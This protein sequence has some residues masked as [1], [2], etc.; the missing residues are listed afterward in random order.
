[1]GVYRTGHSVKLPRLT[2]LALMALVAVVAANLTV[3]RAIFASH[4]DLLPGC[5]LSGMVLEVALCRF[6]RG[7][8][9]ARVF[10]A[11]FVAAGALAAASLLV[12]NSRY[13]T[14][15]YLY[16][17]MASD[18]LTCLPEISYLVRTDRRAFSV[19]F[20]LIVFLPQ[21]GLAS[22][23][24]LLALFVSRGFAGRWSAVEFAGAPGRI[25]E[26]DEPSGACLAP[27]LHVP[28]SQSR[29]AL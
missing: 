2:I 22:T 27:A 7:H 14:Y 13:W 25:D 10:W 6:L 26:R 1:L 19:V 9:R 15:W 24:G 29:R 4:R 17:T 21:V 3:G 28:P 20:A 12:T 11:G 23:G 18:W 5:A 16:F 8:G